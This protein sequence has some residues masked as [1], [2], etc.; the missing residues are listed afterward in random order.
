MRRASFY[1]GLIILGTVGPFAL[2]S[3][4]LEVVSI[5]LTN[6]EMRATLDAGAQGLL[7]FLSSIAVAGLLVAVVESRAMATALL[8]ARMASRPL[9]ARGALARS[10]MSFWRVIV[11]SFIVAIPVGVA[12]SALS[13]LFSSM[14]GKQTDLSVV[15]STLAAALAGAPL[16]YVLSGIVL[17]DV[18]AVRGDPSLVP[19]LPGTEARRRPGRGLRDGRHPPR[20]RRPVGRSRHR[21]PHLRRAGARHE[22]GAGRTGTDD[23][24]DHGRRLRPGDAHLHGVRDRGGAADRDVRRP[25]PGDA[26]PRSCPARRRSRPGDDPARTASVPLADDRDAGR[27]RRRAPRSG[28]SSW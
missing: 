9:S 4:A 5:H 6:A 11:G 27:V 15:S 12:Q 20:R 2:A 7:V 10:R 21:R 17:G 24:R 26:G 22:L 28:A 3:W 23:A 25:H 19:C 13:A 8:G 1:I 16:A 14:V 18:V